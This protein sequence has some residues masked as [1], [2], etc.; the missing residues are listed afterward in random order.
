MNIKN[1]IKEELENFDWIRDVQP[2]TP[3]DEIKSG[4]KYYITNITQYFLD[5]LHNCDEYYES[6]DIFI[7]MPVT[8]DQI[9]NLSRKEV[10]CGICDDGDWWKRYS[11][12]DCNEEPSVALKIVNREND[13]TFWVTDDM[14]SLSPTPIEKDIKINEETGIEW[15]KDIEPETDLGVGA[16]WYK[17]DG[18]TSHNTP[19]IS[20][21]LDKSGT[22]SDIKFEGDKVYMVT[23][24]W[25]DF[26]DSFT[27]SDRGGYGYINRYLAENLFCDEEDWW[28]DYHGLIY[29]WVELVWS[30]VVEDNE[31]YQYI[32]NF[33]NEHLIGDQMRLDGKE[34][35]LSKE[36]INSW[37]G[38]SDVLGMMID[39]LDVFEDLKIN[40]TWAY[41]SAYNAAARDNVWEAASGAIKDVF[42]KGE[43]ESYQ[44]TTNGVDTT[45][46][47]LKFDVTHLFWDVLGEVFEECYEYCKRYYDENPSDDLEQFMEYCD[48]CADIPSDYSY[49]DFLRFY[50]QYQ[51]ELDEFWSPGF[52]E[53]PDDDK[54][55][56]YF[57]EDVYSRM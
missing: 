30:L 3:F 8:V 38:D 41:E 10:D 42:G 9:Y 1:I 48:E 35:I 28:D 26:S 52:D 14:L 51:S 4:S 2:N 37:I 32:I 50:Q 56:E 22:F 17:Y 46:H 15:I 20:K 12:I 43:W 7:N 6:P 54:V 29:D 13:F 16:L 34:T 24:G 45:K 19:Y 27:D 40:L 57:K 49:P 47:L 18:F 21:L 5:A 31:I 23:D 25:C 11:E 36:H 53:Y 44:H 39:K 55:R 33:I